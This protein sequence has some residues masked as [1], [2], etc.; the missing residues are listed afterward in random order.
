MPDLND[1]KAKYQKDVVFLG[2]TFNTIIELDDF[3]EKE[4][5]QYDSNPDAREIC[6]K[7]DINAYPTNMIIDRKGIVTLVKLASIKK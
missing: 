1:L 6:R 5:F 4:S 2:I 7:R 3:I